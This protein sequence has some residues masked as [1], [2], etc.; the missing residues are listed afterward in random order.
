MKGGSTAYTFLYIFTFFFCL[1]ICGVFHIRVL[2]FLSLTIRIFAMQATDICAHA[3]DVLAQS[4]IRRV[5]IT[6][7]RG[8]L[9]VA[10]T[11]KELREMTCLRGCCP[12]LDLKDFEAHEHLLA[13]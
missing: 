8:P 2:P 7:R 10:F 12:V 3:L 11:I 4:R 6:G 1:S 13:G 9:Q 5:V